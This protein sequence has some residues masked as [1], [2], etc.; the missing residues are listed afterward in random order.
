M[1]K[2]EKEKKGL[3]CEYKP[4]KNLASVMIG[5]YGSLFPKICVGVFSQEIQA[6]GY[7]DK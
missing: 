6:D 5:Q 2:A 7:F 1:E 4:T 3:N